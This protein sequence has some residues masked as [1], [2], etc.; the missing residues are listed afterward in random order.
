MTPEMGLELAVNYEFTVGEMTLRPKKVPMLNLYTVE[1]V[2]GN[3]PAVLSGRYTSLHSLGKA[4]QRYIKDK[5]LA[6]ERAAVTNHKR[7]RSKEIQE[8]ITKRESNG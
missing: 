7:Q 6:A 4:V 3:V 8:H 2:K 5:E 1:A